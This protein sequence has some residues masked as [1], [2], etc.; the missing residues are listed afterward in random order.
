[1]REPGPYNYEHFRTSHLLRETAKTIGG[2]GVHAGE[3]APDFE[4]PSISGGTFRL[5]E[6]LERPVLLRFGSYS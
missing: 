5:G 3:L 1:M 4:L 2:A 6:S